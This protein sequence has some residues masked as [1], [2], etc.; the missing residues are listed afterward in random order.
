MLLSDHTIYA[1][2]VSHRTVSAPHGNT[3]LQSVG[4]NFGS[5]FSLSRHFASLVISERQPLPIS[6]DTLGE[7]P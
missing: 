6:A 3:R 7:N 4:E 1:N 2:I 5:A